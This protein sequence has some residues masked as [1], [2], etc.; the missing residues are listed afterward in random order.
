MLSYRYIWGPNEVGSEFEPV[1]GTDI[2]EDLDLIECF[3]EAASDNAEHQRWLPRN[4]QTK[5]ETRY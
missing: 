3:M 5:Q 4:E 1:E 2:V